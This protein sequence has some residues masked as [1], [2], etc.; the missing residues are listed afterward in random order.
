[1]SIAFAGTREGLERQ[2]RAV[3]EDRRRDKEWGVRRFTAQ[4][5]QEPVLRCGR[6][7]CLVLGGNRGGKTVVGAAET[8]YRLLGTHPFKSTHKP[9][10]KVW[11]CSQDL[12]GS[13]DTPH[14][15]LEEL[16]RWIPKDALRGGSWETA[17]SPSGRTLN[18]KNGSLVVFKG[19]DQGPLK[20]ESD[21][22]HWAWLD[23]EPEDKSIW[24]SVLL[25]LA[26]YSGGWMITATPVLSLYGKGWLE[27][28]YDA[29]NND[30]DGVGFE[31]HQLYSYENPHLSTGVL[32]ELFSNL[33]TEERAVRES[34][35]FARL[36]GR[37]L[38]ELASRHIAPPFYPP[39]SWR[40]YLVLDFG[41]SNPSA[42]L[43]AAADP[44]GRLWLWWEHYQAGWRPDQHMA[45]YHAYWSAFCAHWKALGE[46]PPELDVLADPAGFYRKSSSTG[47]ETPSDI[48]EY[49]VMADTLGARWFRPRK[50][51]NADPFAYRVK[52]FLSADMLRVCSNLKSWRWE[53]ERWIYKR[54]RDGLA[55]QEL[56]APE[57]PVDRDNH[58]MDCTRYLANERPD[59]VA[60]TL[61]E[62]DP[63]S[64]RAHQLMRQ[65]DGKR[66]ER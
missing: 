52:R 65:G 54:Q 49:L 36:S 10:I 58:L 64:L 38:S 2:A 31:L 9:P 50:A 32:D 41:F 16:R 33:S 20:F 60:P 26:D 5:Q 37:V 12:P 3:L 1:M 61:P 42:G 6:R 62:P 39:A 51:S 63:R 15:Q 59:P 29:Y 43:F 24:T 21:A 22:I 57:A 45:A 11:A 48:E 8:A 14:K 13:S 25:R 18:L 19:Y 30:R 28:L 40:H 23:E 17:Y 66:D 56:P 4:E 35:A 27:G 46:E 44:D 55:A 47:H 7:G 34:G 53:A